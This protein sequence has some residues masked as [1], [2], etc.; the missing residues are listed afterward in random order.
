M[1]RTR[2]RDKGRAEGGSFV[3]LP[4]SLLNA[5]KFCDLSGKA[6]KLLLDVYAQYKGHNNGD[7]SIAWKLMS[8]RGWKSKQT[9]YAAR[10]E[11]IGK[12]FLMLTRQGGRHQCSLYAV[13]WQSIDE[14]KGKL[15]V[16][17][18]RVAPGNRR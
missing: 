3:A 18:T 5:P 13:T 7:F 10:K 17:A 1:S 14:C 9:L 11:L 15:D 6:V 2:R 4:H 12:G 8:V 16:P